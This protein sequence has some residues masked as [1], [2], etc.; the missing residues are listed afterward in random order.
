MLVLAADIKNTIQDYARLRLATIYLHGYYRPILHNNN[1]K[2]LY[3]ND[4]DNNAVSQKQ[5]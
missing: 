2:Q 4:N 5:K 1:N 3:D